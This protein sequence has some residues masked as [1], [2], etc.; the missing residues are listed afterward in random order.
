M[1]ADVARHTAKEAAKA[2]PPLGVVAAT[3]AGIDL[4]TWVY[5]AALVY[6]GLQ[7][8]YLIWKWRREARKPDPPKPTVPPSA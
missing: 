8:A 4:Q 1:Y 6:T 7:G 2:T 3:L 5:V